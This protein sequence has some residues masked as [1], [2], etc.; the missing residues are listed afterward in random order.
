VSFDLLGCGSD[1]DKDALSVTIAQGPTHG[2]L[3]Y[4]PNTGEYD[5]TADDSY[6]GAD[7][8]TYQVSDGAMDSGIATVSCN[9]TDQ[10]L[11]AQDLNVSVLHDQTVNIDLLGN[12]WDPDGDPLN[13]SI[14]QGPSHGSLN[15]HPSTAKYEYIGATGYVGTD[16]LT[17]KVN[18]GQQDS[19]LATVYINITTP[20]VGDN[21]NISNW[22][23]NQAE[24]S[25][26][27]DPTNPQRLFNVAVNWEQGG[28]PL[29]IFA[30]YSTDGGATWTRRVMATGL[31]GG[32]SLPGGRADVHATFD[33]HGN[34]FLIYQC[35]QVIY[36]S[37]STSATGR[38]G[39]PNANS[40][41]IDDFGRPWAANQWVDY[42][43]TVRPAGRMAQ[44][45]TITGNTGDTITVNQA[46]DGV[47]PANTPYTIEQPVVLPGNGNP[48]RKSEVV[49]V[50]TDGGQTFRF[51][52]NIGRNRPS[53]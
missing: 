44:T 42:S 50:S 8:F 12:G 48:N 4:N 22:P 28:A 33:S 34:L 3:S 6:T 52:K 53:A 25:I 21:V 39:I 27:V 31:P 17:Y 10:A 41:L 9:V 43:I 26:T 19:N 7:P 15:Y 1:A 16:C 20:N 23:G 47:I 2:S 45:R 32:D 29:G 35:P 11:L 36:E 49:V 51:L 18:D 46:W 14:V 38:E 40:S 30:A 13:V 5:Y 37:A 24:T